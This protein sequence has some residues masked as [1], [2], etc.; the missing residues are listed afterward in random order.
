MEAQYKKKYKLSVF[1]CVIHIV[2]FLGAFS[3]P[4]AM[5]PIWFFILLFV[6]Y[7]CGILGGFCLIALAFGKPLDK[8]LEE[9]EQ[10]RKKD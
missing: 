3:L 2:C 10:S 9:M 7:L 5:H 1:L 6:S 8:F 4:S